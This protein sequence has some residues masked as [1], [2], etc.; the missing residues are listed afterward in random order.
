[1]KFVWILLIWFVLFCLRL[2]SSFQGIKSLRQLSGNKILVKG[3]ISS[4]PIL[5][6]RTQSFNIGRISIRTKAYP[7]YEYGD[8]VELFGNLEER[9]VNR[10]QSRFSLLYPNIKLIKSDSSIISVFKWRNKIEAIYNQVLSEPEASL[11]SGIVLG[12]KR[13]LPLDFWQAL[14]RTGTLHIV[15]ASG[16]NVTV[17]IGAVILGLAGCLK[18]GSAIALGILA[19]M[20][21]TL[22]A[23]AEPAIVR[24]AIMGSLAYFGQ[25]LGR[26]ADGLRLLLVAGGVMLLAKP[27]LVWDVGFQLSVMATTGLILIA[28]GLE[29]YLMNLG[30]MGKI[31][32]ETLAAQIAVW[33]I[34]LIN[35][36]QLSLF[37]V[38]VNSLILWLVPMVMGLGAILACLGLVWLELAK[39]VGW[40]V[41]VPLTIMVRVIEWF[42]TKSWMSYQVGQI[43]AWWAAGYYLVLLLIII[44]AGVKGKN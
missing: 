10:W 2:N 7:V 44:K 35:F 38:L 23:G 17:V 41:Y 12:A 33:P 15:V 20:V 26:K 37:A 36:G 14:Q 42:G 1:M 6:G 3:R 40:V 43:S 5:Q 21:Y 13:A 34:L 4:E 16:Y 19:V 9:V 29:K 24:A 28:P 8:K 25:I 31:I 32:S 39:L 22:M 18:R 30:E 27:D 11:L